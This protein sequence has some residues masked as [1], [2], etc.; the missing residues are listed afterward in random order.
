MNS[1]S[2]KKSSQ[3]FVPLVVLPYYNIHRQQ[4]NIQ[5]LQNEHIVNETVDNVQVTNEEG[6][7]DREK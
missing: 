4:I 2:P 7:K 6:V 1:S 5:N 3:V